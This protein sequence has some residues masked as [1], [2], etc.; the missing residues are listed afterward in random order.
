MKALKLSVIDVMNECSGLVRQVA[1]PWLGVAWLCSMPLRLL[2]AFWLQEL[3]HLGSSAHRFGNYLSDLALYLIFALALSVYGR[4]VFVR[5]CNLASP[6]GGAPGTAALKVP[7]KDYATHLYLVLIVEVLWYLLFMTML[8]IPYLACLVPLAA[9]ISFNVK[10]PGVLAPLKELLNFGVHLRVLLGLGLFFGMAL[11]IVWINFY[12]ASL[13]MV[14]LAKG[15]VGVDV[16]Q[17]EHLLRWHEWFPVLPYEFLPKVLLL[18]AAVLVLEPFWIAA[19]VLL[20]R[21]LRAR[22]NGEDLRL[23]FDELRREVA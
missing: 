2:Q 3:A 10:T 13:A 12:F 9:A 19:H 18:F 21:S 5:S 17:W 20:V 16:A 11:L 23:W 8:P 14:Y 7:L 22:Q 15:A 6:G 4:C 1:A